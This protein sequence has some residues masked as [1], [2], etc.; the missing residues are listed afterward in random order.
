[1]KEKW[2]LNSRCNQKRAPSTLNV[3]TEFLRLSKQTPPTSNP[4]THQGRASDGLWHFVLYK[5]INS[6]I[7]HHEEHQFGYLLQ[8]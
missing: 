4:S 8:D 1:M 7:A 5:E 2:S 3:G 6:E